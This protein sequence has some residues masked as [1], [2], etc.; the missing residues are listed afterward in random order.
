[1]TGTERPKTSPLEWRVKRE[2]KCKGEMAR[3]A[4]NV[5]SRGWEVGVCRLWPGRRARAPSA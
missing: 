4:V 5:T 1:M 3:T 2:G